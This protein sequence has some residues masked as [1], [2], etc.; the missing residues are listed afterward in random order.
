MWCCGCAVKPGSLPEKK[1]SEDGLDPD[2]RAGKL[3]PLEEL[4]EPVEYDVEEEAVRS[5]S[6]GLGCGCVFPDL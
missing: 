3:K 4:K 5:P 6:L 1:L 2:K